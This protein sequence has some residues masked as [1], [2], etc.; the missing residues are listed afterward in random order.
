M[1]LKKNPKANLE[2]RKSLF[3]EIGLIIAL[4]LVIIMFSVSQ[5]KKEIDIDSVVEQAAEVIEEI[6]VTKEEVKPVEQVKQNNTVITDIINIVSN[7]TNIEIETIFED[8][9]TDMEIPEI[10]FVEEELDETPPVIRAEKMAAFQGGD[11]ST[12]TNWVKARIKYPAE[13][14]EFGIQGRVII[15]F[16]VEKDG[17]ITNIKTLQAVDQSLADEAI[18]IMKTAPRWEPGSN[19]NIPVRLVYRVPIDFKIN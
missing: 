17:R 3:M 16:V 1:E 7:D 11:V 6:E 13:A 5:T 15:E 8:F 9:D 2:N 19:R 4:G 10:E 18:R 12:F 14:M